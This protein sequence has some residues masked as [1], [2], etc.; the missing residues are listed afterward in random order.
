M[1]V[2]CPS[3][4]GSVTHPPLPSFVFSC[5]SDCYR[6]QNKGRP[7]TL[8]LL[9]WVF[10]LCFPYI[11]KEHLNHSVLFSWR[12]HAVSRLP[13]GCWC[14]NSASDLNHP[15]NTLNSV[16]LGC[17][18]SSGTSPLCPLFLT[19]L[20]DC[21]KINPADLHFW[22]PAMAKSSSA[23]YSKATHDRWAPSVIVSSLSSHSV[24]HGD[25]HW[26]VNVTS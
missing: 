21:G 17:S 19:F 10:P 3:V 8:S 16:S 12:H 26:S 5:N 24:V 20:R 23:I 1:C 2:S 22:V 4:T 7:W 6:L 15:F 9:C 14:R 18:S 25:L 13:I 11:R